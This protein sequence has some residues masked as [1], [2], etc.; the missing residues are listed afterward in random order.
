[1]SPFASIEEREPCRKP[2]R[3]EPISEDFPLNTS[4]YRKKNIKNS[5][6]YHEWRKVSID[7]SEMSKEITYNLSSYEHETDRLEKIRNKN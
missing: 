1:M 7:E 2:I 4:Q 5:H 3:T 6:N